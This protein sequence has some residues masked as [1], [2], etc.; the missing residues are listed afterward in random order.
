M[1]ASDPPGNAEG[2][3]AEKTPGPLE[4]HDA[5]SGAERKLLDEFNSGTWDESLYFERLFSLK[6]IE[7][8]KRRLAVKEAM[9][10]FNVFLHLTAYLS[11]IAY[12]VILGVLYRPALP[13]VLIPIG[14]W[15]A[16]I[17]Y[18]FYWAFS[19]KNKTAKKKKKPEK[20]YKPLGWIDEDSAADGS[21]SSRPD[22]PE[23]DE[24][25][26]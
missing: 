5:M 20:T 23:S 17:G 21:D 18:H 15:T 7:E 6:E 1:E 10:K 24:R 11:G 26:T 16:G 2:Q 22:V 13:W 14:L 8:E 3:S 4:Y 12:L 19:K 9:N 25:G